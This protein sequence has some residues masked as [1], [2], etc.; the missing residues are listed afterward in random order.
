MV[1]AIRFSLHENAV[2][3]TAPAKEQPTLEIPAPDY[4]GYQVDEDEHDLPDDDILAT[5]GE[6]EGEEGK[7][8]KAPRSRPP[9]QN[10]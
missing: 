10:I 6:G 4:E 2:P 1:R 5:E 8:N 7:D 9:Q 3:G